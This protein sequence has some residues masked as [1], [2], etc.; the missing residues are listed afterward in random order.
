VQSV[1]EDDA[2]GGRYP[3]HLLKHAEMVDPPRAPA[4]WGCINLDSKLPFESKARPDDIH[5]ESELEK[6]KTVKSF[7]IRVSVGNKL[8]C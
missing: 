4:I 6:F 2:E 1:G 7:D 3:A 8:I 5:T